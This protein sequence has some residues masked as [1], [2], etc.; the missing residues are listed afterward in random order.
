MSGLYKLFVV[1][2]IVGDERQRRPAPGRRQAVQP[3]RPQVVVD[4][5]AKK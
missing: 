2:H 1:L 5:F 4:P 3:R